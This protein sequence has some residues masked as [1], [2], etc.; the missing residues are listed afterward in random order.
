MLLV[1]HTP[2]PV[3]STCYPYVRFLNCRGSLPELH[4]LVTAGIG[5]NVQ[6]SNFDGELRVDWPEKR[7]EFS[8]QSFQIHNSNIRGIAPRFFAE[9]SSNSLESLVLN[10]VNGTFELNKQTLGGLENVLKSIR[11]S[12]RW[13]GD[14][15]YF[16]ELKQLHT[17]YLGLTHLNEVPANFGSLIKRLVN[18]DLSKNELTRL[19]WDALASRIRDFEVQRFRLADNPWHCDCSLRP[20]LEVPDEYL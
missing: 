2:R 15:S 11:I 6:V 10:A 9:F 14:I 5:T 16:A 20:L 1:S 7:D 13:L 8:V 12:S 17:F 3:E 4:E 18:V 19:P